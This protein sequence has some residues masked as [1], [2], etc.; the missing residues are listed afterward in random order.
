MQEH[1]A[2]DAVAGL[3]EFVRANRVIDARPAD[4]QHIKPAHSTEPSSERIQN[5]KAGAIGEEHAQ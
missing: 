4:D 5:D 2:R 1:V 3:R